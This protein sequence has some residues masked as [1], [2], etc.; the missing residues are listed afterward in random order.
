M[1]Y[2][3]TFINF[4]SLFRLLINS[5]NNVIIFELYYLGIYWLSIDNRFDFKSMSVLYTSIVFILILSDIIMSAKNRN[6]VKIFTNLVTFVLIGFFL[7]SLTHNLLDLNNDQ[8][9]FMFVFELLLVLATTCISMRY[10]LGKLITKALDSYYAEHSDD[11]VL[12][13]KQSIYDMDG[14]FL[15]DDFYYKMKGFNPFNLYHIE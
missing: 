3:K 14:D 8:N 10:L 4:I 12:V 7:P 1:L 6:S 13:K 2:N 9:K 15:S 5:I 11:F